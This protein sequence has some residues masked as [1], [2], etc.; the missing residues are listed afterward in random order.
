MNTYYQHICTFERVLKELVEH[1]LRTYGKELV[2]RLE[3]YNLLQH[4]NN[5]IESSTALGFILEEF[6]VSKL[7][8]Y[9]TCEPPQEYVIER[10]NRATTTDSFDCFCVHDGVKF[11]INVKCTRDLQ[12]NNAIAAI[13]KLYHNYVVE[14]PD[15][16][17]AFI[18]LKLQY[19]IGEERLERPRHITTLAMET[20]CLEEMDFSMGHKQDNRSW[21]RTKTRADRNSGRL[22][23]SPAWRNEHRVPEDQI[24]YKNT[25]NMLKGLFEQN[26]TIDTEE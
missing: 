20:Y 15:Q 12:S 25:V 10:T 26:T 4:T 23:A 3:E 6:V 24:A 19:G 18:I 7:N 11:L 21:S 2:L 5:C 9:T 1:I 13:N 8:I 14:A 16:P 17:K 22:E